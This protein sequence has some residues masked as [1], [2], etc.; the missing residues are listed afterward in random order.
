MTSGGVTETA[1]VS[2]T[3]TPVNDAPV[4]TVPGA[5]TTTEDNNRQITGTTVADVDGGTLTTTL[6]I[7]SSA[8]TLS[9]VTGGGAVI[10]N[11]GTATVTIQGTVSQVN[12]ALATIT[13]TPISDYN[14]GSPST[15]FNLTVSTTD[16]TATDS[17]T[18]AIN[19]TPWRTSWP[20]RSPAEYRAHVQRSDRSGRRK[21][22]QLRERGPCRDVGDAREQRDGVVRGQRRADVYPDCQLQRQ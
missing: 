12:A 11:N 13:Y 4:N 21:P 10:N 20:I 9:V 16:G 8:G 1:T 5:Q 15:P 7:P 2:V 17:D 6:S 19:V 18:V 3:V 14:T 22:G